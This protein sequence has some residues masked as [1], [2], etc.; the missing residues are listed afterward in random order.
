[1]APG[2]ESGCFV[3]IRPRNSTYKPTY[4]PSLSGPCMIH[5]PTEVPLQKRWLLYAG[6]WGFAFR[7]CILPDPRSIALL[8]W[9]LP[10]FPIGLVA[11][12]DRR[13]EN[14]VAIALIWIAYI[15]HGYFTMSTRET[16]RL[17][18]LLSLLAVTLILNVAGC[19]RV[20]KSFH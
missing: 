13:S 19:Y 5:E 15:V 3:P 20:D 18:R 6:A 2:L 11:W 4:I 12:F 17:Y 8:I 9:F 14:L 7:C 1:M 10:F 16:I